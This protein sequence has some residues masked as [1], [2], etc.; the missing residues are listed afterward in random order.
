NWDTV[1][2]AKAGWQ[3]VRRAFAYLVH[4][5]RRGATRRTLMEAV[6]GS[7]LGQSSLPRTLAALQQTLVHVAGDELAARL[8]TITDDHCMLNPDLYRSDVELFQNTYALATHTEATTGLKAAAPLYAQAL[9]LYGGPYLADIGRTS[10]AQ[11]RRD[12]LA[13]HYTN[14]CVRLAEHAFDAER[15]HQCVEL[16]QQALDANMAA[17]QVTLWLLRA[18]AALGR[19]AEFTHAYAAYLRAVHRAPFDANGRN[20]PVVAEYELL[21]KARAVG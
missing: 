2:S 9:D 18:Y 5:G 3:K 13:N 1:S 7:E 21:A 4:C 11:E 6:W 17:D 8:L 12:L 16:C 15:Y 10:W 14:G 20:D 19:T